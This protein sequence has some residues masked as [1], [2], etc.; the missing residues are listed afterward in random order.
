MGSPNEQWLRAGVFFPLLPFLQ[1]RLVVLSL[2]FQSFLACVNPLSISSSKIATEQHKDMSFQQPTA[3]L[4]WLF[5]STY[6]KRA[7]KYGYLAG[8]GYFRIA[9]NHVIKWDFVYFL[10]MKNINKS[11]KKEQVKHR[12][13]KHFKHLGNRGGLAVVAITPPSPIRGLSLE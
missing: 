7:Q 13:W 11:K 3:L 9:W 6:E 8:T 12:T 10:E 1:F 2:G 5:T 4:G